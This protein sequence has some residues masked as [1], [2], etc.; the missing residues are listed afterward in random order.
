VIF[1]VATRGHLT[2]FLSAE[3]RKRRPRLTA[4]ESPA[5]AEETAEALRQH[6]GSADDLARRAWD[7]EHW[8]VLEYDSWA[9]YA[10]GRFGSDRI[11][12]RRTVTELLSGQ[13]L[14]V[15]QISAATGVPRSTVSDDLKAQV[16]DS[17][18]TLFEQAGRNVGVTMPTV[19][20]GKPM[21][22]AQ[23]AA[24]HREK[25][26]Q[27]APPPAPSCRSVPAEEPVTG[28]CARCG[29]DGTPVL[30]NGEDT[31]LFCCDDCYAGAVE[32]GNPVSRP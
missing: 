11:A 26:R 13:G 15:G 16:S 1:A 21:T 25:H 14:S 28:D 29:E 7:E 17:P 4:R 27:A 23:R 2:A 8:K 5:S 3:H 30:V 12:A 6:I 18:D 20:A 24:K 22:G 10:A 9:A 19:S 31:G 32:T